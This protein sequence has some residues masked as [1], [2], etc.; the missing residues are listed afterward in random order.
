M[1]IVYL[2]ADRGI[3][4]LGDKGASVHV[5]EFT[6]ALARAGHEVTLLCATQGKGNPYP[7]ARLIE[8]P[9]D[10]DPAEIRREGKRLG[11]GP[12]DCDQTAC[13]EIDKLICDRR[14]AARAFDALDAAGVR[15]DA[16]YERYAL[17]HRSGG[18][19][20]SALGVPYVLEVNAPL[21]YEQ[22]RFRGLRLKALAEEAEVAAF[23]QA[24][25]VVAVSEAVREHVL[26]RRVP[27]KRV[28]VLPN[29][30]DISRF[31]PQVDGQGVRQ[32]LGLDG[33]SVIGFVGSLKPWHGLDFLLDAFMLVSRQSPE[34][35]L[36]V[37]GEGPG[38]AALQSRATENGF[39][40]KVIMTGRVPH[41]DIPGYLAA[42]DLTVAPYLP[43]DGFYFSPLKVVESLAVGRPVVAPRIG[44]LPSL[45]EDSVTGLLFPPGDLAAC[46]GCILTLLN[47]PS[48][49]QA[50]GH[51]AGE[52]AG[53]IFGWDKTARQVTDII[54]AMRPGPM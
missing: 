30:V 54:A 21:V 7:P 46:V 39:G 44:Q 24:D 43:Q 27:A 10:A 12:E 22:E 4:V 16:L 38:S 1:N 9:P 52:V 20:A 11:I 15:P 2:C 45:I 25:H 14:I 3:P 13:R 29:G 34:A 19:L 47:E 23:H 41:E 31:H 36:L 50:M 32:R 17:F 53:G 33:R 18:D 42:M 40:G 26:S 51:R 35:V 8:L 48:Q 37:V 6:T 28:T 49:R 5:R